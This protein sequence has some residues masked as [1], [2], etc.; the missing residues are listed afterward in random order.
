MKYTSK[1]L[2]R[3]FGLYLYTYEDFEISKTREKN[4]IKEIQ[5]KV[6]EIILPSVGPGVI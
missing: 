4:Y 3:I 6:V 5:I 2:I 1:F